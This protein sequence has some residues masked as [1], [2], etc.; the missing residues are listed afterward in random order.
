MVKKEK[1]AYD[2]LVAE[3]KC[4]EKIVYKEGIGYAKEPVCSMQDLKSR[5][6]QTETQETGGGQ[7]TQ[8][9]HSH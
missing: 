4:P 3:G 8:E 9:E 2:Q 6:Q 7:E 1:E 5:M